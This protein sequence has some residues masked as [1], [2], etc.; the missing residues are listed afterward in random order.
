MP[1]L[2]T[3]EIAHWLRGCEPT[4]AAELKGTPPPAEE[5]ERVLPSVLRLGALLDECFGRSPDELRDR[6]RQD[7]VQA[8]TRHVLAQ[9][10]VA[11]RLRL[12][13]W[14]AETAEQE[15]FP[16]RIIGD[17]QGET[18]AFLRAELLRLHRRASLD[19]I[20]SPDR[21]AALLAACSHAVITETSP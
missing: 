9:L 18:G 16:S 12:L 1:D 17:G 3:D 4:V 7:R 13:Q 5:H 19:R 8:T 20:F 14:F 10:G 21:I 6:F 15:E 2:S 11:R